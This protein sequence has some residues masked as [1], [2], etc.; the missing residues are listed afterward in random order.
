MSGGTAC[1]NREHRPFWVVLQ[2]NQNTS[3]F[4]GYRPTASDYSEVACT[5]GGCRSVWRTKAA[6]VSEL[7]DQ[8][9]GCGRAAGTTC[10]ICRRH[11]CA[12]CMTDHHHEGYGTPSDG[13]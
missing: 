10:R 4:N 12:S 6:Y 11:L 9:R 5:V 1:R 8:C 3:A 7:P 13:R 2:R